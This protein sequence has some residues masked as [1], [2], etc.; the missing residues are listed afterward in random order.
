MEEQN[1]FHAWLSQYIK[2]LNRNR[3]K[4]I[5]G[6]IRTAASPGF[7]YFFLVILSAA[8]ATLGLINDSPAVIIG[9]MVVAPLM[10]PILGVGLGSITAD[11]KLTRNSIS[12]LIRGAIV[13]I[14]LSALLTLTNIYLPFVP[15]LLD[16]PHE[17][18]SRTQP[19]A[20]DLIIALAGGLAAA[21]ALSQPNLSAALPG[22]AIATALMPP[23]CTIGIGFALGRWDICRRCVLTVPDKRSHHRLRIQPGLF[24]GRFLTAQRTGKR[25]TSQVPA[26]SRR[27]DRNPAHPPD[28]R[29]CADCHPGPGKPADQYDC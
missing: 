14:L 6:E 2:P 11:G 18:L 21:Y 19:T 24:P 20:N 16:I 23:L 27:I 17:I 9:A 25:E 1:G 8:I 4:E 26:G 10:S 7:D 5:I 12:A 13:A 3:R 28:H 15:S 29:R 22:V